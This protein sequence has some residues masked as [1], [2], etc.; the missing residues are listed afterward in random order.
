[1]KI[2]IICLV[3]GVLAIIVYKLLNKFLLNKKMN[4]IVNEVGNE[5]DNIEKASVETKTNSN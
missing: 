3:S 1:M 5:S 4:T 2:G